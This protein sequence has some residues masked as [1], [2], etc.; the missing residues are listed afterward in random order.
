MVIRVQFGFSFWGRT[1]HT[2]QE[3]VTSVRFS[4]DVINQDGAKCV[5]A[6]N[7]LLGGVHGVLSDSL[8]KLSQFVGI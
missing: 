7:A 2:M 8:A 5:G 3:Y 1:L 4:E 6:R